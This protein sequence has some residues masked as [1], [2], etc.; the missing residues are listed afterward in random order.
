[1][2]RN[3]GGLRGSPPF[4]AAGIDAAVASIADL[5]RALAPDAP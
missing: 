3:T 4:L 2:K 1:M 5:D